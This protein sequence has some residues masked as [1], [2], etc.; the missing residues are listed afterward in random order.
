ILIPPMTA[1]HGATRQGPSAGLPRSMLE[2]LGGAGPLAQGG[3]LGIRAGE[4]GWGQ[5][6]SHWEHGECAEGV[7]DGLHGDRALVAISGSKTTRGAPVPHWRNNPGHQSQVIGALISPRNDDKLR[8]GAPWGAAWISKQQENQMV[9]GLVAKLGLDVDEIKSH[10]LPAKTASRIARLIY[11]HSFGFHKSVDEICLHAKD[12]SRL[13]A[14][15]W[16]TFLSTWDEQLGMTFGSQ[17][18]E[19]ASQRDY[20]VDEFE[21]TAGESES[22]RHGMRR[23]VHYSLE[24]ML[25][26]R[27]GMEE[28]DILRSQLEIERQNHDTTSKKLTEETVKVGEVHATIDDYKML[29]DTA[30]GEVKK[31]QAENQRMKDAHRDIQLEIKNKQQELG[32]MKAN[33]M[34]LLKSIEQLRAEVGYKEGQQ[35]Q[36]VKDTEANITKYESSSAQHANEMQKIKESNYELAWSKAILSGQCSTLKVWLRV[37]FCRITLSGTVLELVVWG[38]DKAGYGQRCED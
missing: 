35:N 29:A 22:L 33:E 28:R 9:S 21:K 26:E 4:Y 27:M 2:N 15:I 8:S 16:R 36:L 17:L 11:V 6:D 18:V 3:V 5:G 31:M 10:G 13:L 25:H 20:L 30:R 19:A 38:G 37:A 32:A 23:M 7:A 24:R 34:H 1:P 12:R 14:K